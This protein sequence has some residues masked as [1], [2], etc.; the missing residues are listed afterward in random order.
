[1]KAT[2]KKGCSLLFALAV[3]VTS[4]FVTPPTEAKAADT[5]LYESDGW[6]TAT[7]NT[8]VRFS[9]TVD[10]SSVI[11][12]DVYT[13][14]PANVKVVLYNSA[15]T[16]LSSTTY[17]TSDYIPDTTDSG[18]LYY[19][20]VLTN[21]TWDAGDYTI[22]LTFASDNYYSA[23]VDQTKAKA[24]ISQT[25]ATITKGF[26]KK[27][28]V[29]NGKVKSWSSSKKAVATVDK[30]G[31]VTAKKTGK[32]VIT[33]TLTD[34]SKLKCT[35]KV[36]ENKY[37]ATKPTLSDCYYGDV[38]FSAYSAQYDKNG[39]LVIK[40]VCANNSGKKINHFENLKI[41]VKDANGKLIGK[42]SAK[43]VNSGQSSGSTKTYT[44]TIKKSALKKK[45]AD[46]RN[47]QHISIDGT[48]VYYSYY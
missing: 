45:N 20:L 34:G 46:L 11:Y 31:K 48:W 4:V 15:G 5:V 18:D 8:E 6:Q 3:L 38:I 29:S 40:A 41:T 9:F 39:N 26:T 35:V 44:F 42:Y 24:T 33:A 1:M 16:E 19:V 47:A 30:K 12:S 27:L 32:A 43:K 25:K 37:S 13:A 22:G 17:S 14:A 7:A 36:V 10:K 28:S 23:Y 2:L 21:T